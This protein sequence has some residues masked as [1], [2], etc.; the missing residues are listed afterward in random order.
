[1]SSTNLADFRDQYIARARALL[2]GVDLAQANTNAM[3]IN[4][5]LFG[6]LDKVINA[7]LIGRDTL[8]LF[9]AMTSAEIDTWL[10]DA[11]HRSAWQRL[12]TDEARTIQVALQDDL[13]RPK[14]LGSTLAWT[15]ILASS[16]MQT[17]IQ[18]KAVY[19]VPY[20]AAIP[21]CLTL[22]TS[23]RTSMD[24]FA[25]VQA[26]MT[27]IYASTNWLNAIAANSPAQDAIGASLTALR[28]LA[29]SSAAMNALYTK[30]TS[31]MVFLFADAAASVDAWNFVSSEISAGRTTLA[32]AFFGDAGVRNALHGNTGIT[33]ALNTTAN[34]LY[35]WLFTNKMTVFQRTYAA[36]TTQSGAAIGGK[37]LMLA[38][39][40]AYSAAGPSYFYLTGTSSQSLQTANGAGYITLTT[41]HK[42]VGSQT[43]P[44]YFTDASTGSYYMTLGYLV[45]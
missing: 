37:I 11:A 4:G 14:L 3:V 23:S 2:Q 5:A 31:I 12:C 6:A 30:L 25:S 22:T 35:Q 43:G 19:L 9:D 16:V 15:D 13:L 41:A 8:A 34:A 44:L 39:S 21:G 42:A 28:E 40:G 18:G 10:A 33:T 32:S 24:K 45:I 29:K 1:M 7:P 20:I 36:S 38:M 27:L 17:W 26:A